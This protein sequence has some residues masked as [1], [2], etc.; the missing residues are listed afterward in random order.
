MTKRF[1]TFQFRSCKLLVFVVQQVLL[2][3]HMVRFHKM[4]HHCSYQC[5][6]YRVFAPDTKTELLVLG[7]RTLDGCQLYVQF[8]CTPKENIKQGNEMEK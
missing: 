8:T 4:E 1:I 3:R 2:M 6:V 5:T 7:D